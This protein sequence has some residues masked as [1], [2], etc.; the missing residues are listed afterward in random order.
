MKKIIYSFELVF[1]CLF[2]ISISS[3]GGGGDSSV[4]AAPI[5]LY[6]DYY[7]KLQGTWKLVSRTIDGERT[8]LT[9]YAQKL[10]FFHQNGIDNY[11]RETFDYTVQKKP[12]TPESAPTNTTVDQYRLYKDSE[13]DQ[14]VISLRNKSYYEYIYGI[15]IIKFENNN[16]RLVRN[17]I[18]ADKYICNDVWEKVTE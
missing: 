14:Y 4:E 15:Y 7:N 6:Q 9:Y 10:T 16:T 17:E 8:D 3:C 12:I 2:A 1:M 13:Y 18:H 11:R 5:D